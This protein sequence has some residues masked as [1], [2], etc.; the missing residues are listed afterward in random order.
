MKVLL[1]PLFYDTAHPSDF[2]G[3]VDGFEQNGNEAII[4]KNKHEAIEFK[5]DV[6]IFQ[7]GVEVGDL[8]EIK[9]KSCATLSMYTGD[10]RFTPMESLMRYR[11]IVDVYALPFAGCY[12]HLFSKILGKR[13]CFHWEAIQNWRFIEPKN[14][15]SG[16]IVFIGNAYETTQSDRLQLASFLN[17]HVPNF[18]Y[19]GSI[20]YSKGMLPVSETP[21]VYNNSYAAIAENNF[22]V[23]NYF[24]QRNTGAM[25]AGTCTIMKRFKN[26]EKVGRCNPYFVNAQNCFIYNDNYEL[27]NIC[28]FVNGNSEIRNKVA[29]NAYETA[30]NWFTYKRW[31]LEYLNIL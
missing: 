10:F 20:P 23:D 8:K 16:S 18:E 24:S 26:I 17:K 3:M 29:R 28:E 25:S 21:R 7:G 2:D 27:L 1:I 15:D 19:Y 12:L 11:S 4:Y 9:E 13:C 6:I 30:V 14:I 31:A 22:F 5:P